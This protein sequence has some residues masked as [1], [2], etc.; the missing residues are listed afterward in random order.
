[1]E[2]NKPPNIEPGTTDLPSEAVSSQPN[3]YIIDLESEIED[4]EYSSSDRVENSEDD[5][6]DTDS[7]DEEEIDESLSSNIIREIQDGLYTCLVC[8]S[9][10][11]QDSTVWSCRSCFR[12]YD[13]DCIKDWATRGSST[14]KASKE[15][16]CPS[17]NIATNKIPSRFTCWCGRTTKPQKNSLIPFSCGS[18]CTYK[19]DT[20]IHSCSSVCHPGFHP[21]CGAMGPLM[22]CQCGSHEQQLPCLITPYSTGWTCEDPCEVVLCD[23]GHNCTK[24][25]HIGF[26]GPCEE[27]V[28]VKCYCGKHDLQVKCS[29]K[30]LKLCKLDSVE[31]IGGATC[32]EQTK[33]F[34]DC[35]EHFEVY[36]CQPLP[37][38]E[39]CK[40]SPSKVET[41][42]CGSTKVVSQRTKCTDPIPE[43]EN[44]CEKLLPCGCYC[45]LKC[46]E[47]DCK[48]Y[49]WFEEPCSCGYELFRVPCKFV[50]LGQKPRC[51]RKC[52][53][54]LNCKRHYH[55]EICCPFEKV[56][57]EREKL[58][59]KAIRN[60]T[61]SNF[62]DDIMLLEAEHICTR[63]CNR[64]KS[65]G[66]HYCEALCHSGNCS[67][68]LESSSDDLI[69]HCG[70]TVLQA[71]VRCG[72][73]L[74][75]KEQ[76]VRPKECSH[77]VEP[78]PCHDDSKPCPKC[79]TL[80]KK[81]CNCGM[82]LDIPGV[83]CSQT[84][85]TCGH[86]CLVP[87]SC[88]HACLRV[89]N[90]KCTKEN[91]HDS[92]TV[93]RS[94][95]AKRRT[96]CPH[97]CKLKC[98]SNK[99]GKSTNCDVTAC[100]ELVQVSCECGR[101]VTKVK[102]SATDVEPSKI[103]YV[104]ECDE[105]CTQA[106]RDKELRDAFNMASAGESI[107]DETY[108]SSILST[109]SRQ[110]TWCSKIEETM[111]NF[112]IDYHKQAENGE[113]PKRTHHFAPMTTPQ[114]EFVHDLGEALG[115][116]T[117]AQD[118]E[119]K[120]SVFIVITRNSKV[121]KVTV[122]EVLQ[123]RKELVEQ[124]AKVENTKDFNA[125]VIQ[126]VFFAITKQDIEA[127]LQPVVQKFDF[128]EPVLKWVRD[129]TFIFYSNANY[130]G[131]ADEKL[132]YLAKSVLSVLR[133]KS[134]AFDCKMCFIDD[135][136]E[137]IL[138]IAEDRKAR[139]LGK[140][141][142]LQSENSFD[143]L[144]GNYQ[145]NEEQEAADKFNNEQKVV[146]EQHEGEEVDQVET[147]K[148]QESLQQAAQEAQEAP[149]VEE[150][151]DAEVA[152]VQQVENVQQQDAPE[153]HQSNTEAK[154]NVEVQQEELEI[155]EQEIQEEKK[156]GQA[157]DAN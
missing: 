48:C 46:H 99:I 67:V 7:S 79:T 143:H 31:F 34:Y 112:V 8:T 55:R 66:L 106:K 123:R 61:R 119:P 4:E 16:R 38:K 74:V 19:Y 70:K 105:D 57:F 77:K 54:L 6:S 17:C 75:C 138:K 80:V 69:C 65:C 120:R 132:P 78:H 35:D 122:S 68:C 103:G 83:M 145:Q 47:G 71:P 101:L 146:V 40:L 116:Y 141:S 72:T 130:K 155:L 3:P 114:R 12:V 42:Y 63:T 111:R 107:P 153:V 98:H 148:V 30:N 131:A 58:K 113:S 97:K 125:L 82:K 21:I 27:I 110:T 25:C 137:H 18:S 128:E 9:E 51:K 154:Q 139:T 152:Q 37:E 150:L 121:P 11:D 39:V 1:M 64:L 129:S 108:T 142:G 135:D 73:T 26:C 49:N 85:I 115:L 86:T 60:Y 118:V 134:M 24:G 14:D 133:D 92:S 100:S 140:L 23:L 56:A 144:D 53:I 124:E 52:A 89:C 41:C 87:K 62:N 84:N 81:P 136:A 13:L 147:E 22:K 5:D 156:D 126:D 109:F 94:D 93:C 36:S 43:C 104:L 102:C 88:G 151:Q 32:N 95:C 44:V 15:W 50:Q 59:K 149:E 45:L 127:A 90:P 117:E 76:C 91:V 28:E 29:E 33:V 96:N 10:I 157:F 2:R 20:C